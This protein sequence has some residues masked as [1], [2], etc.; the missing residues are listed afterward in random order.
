MGVFRD[1]MRKG[2]AVLHQTMGDGAIVFD[3]PPQEDENGNPIP[4]ETTGIKVR[5][6]EHYLPH[7]D[8]KGTNYHYAEV[9]DDSPTAV[10]WLNDPP[11]FAPEYGRYFLTEYGRGYKIDAVS[12]PDDQT[13]NAKVIELLASDMEGWPVYPAV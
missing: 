7:G 13:Q 8:L 6:H 3:W 9:E 10:F 1:E 2:R 4:P 12:P 5:V 11:G